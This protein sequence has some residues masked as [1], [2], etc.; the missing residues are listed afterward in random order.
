[1]KLINCKNYFNQDSLNEVCECLE[2]GEEVK[3]YINWVGYSL[4][5]YEQENYKDA[6]LKKY[7]DR[8]SVGIEK[9]VRCY[10]YFY[11]LM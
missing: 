9:G 4:N 5:T 1:M 11:K 3:V 2:K 10:S 8:L 7:G 6:L